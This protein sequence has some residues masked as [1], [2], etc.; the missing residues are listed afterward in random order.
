MHQQHGTGVFQQVVDR[1]P[2]LA[3]AF[4]GKMGHARF[5]QP[6]SQGQQVPGHR[7]KRLECRAP[8]AL[9]PYRVGHHPTGRHALLMDIPSR[10][11]W[12]HHVHATPPSTLGL[13]GYPEQERRP[14]VLA[15]PKAAGNS[16]WCRQGLQVQ[17]CR[18]LGAPIRTRPR[19][20]PF[21]AH[22]TGWPRHG[23]RPLLFHASWCPRGMR[24]LSQFFIWVNFGYDLPR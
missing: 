24:V 13:A 21:R 7:A 16:S 14:C 6:G 23:E 11:P 15:F 12:K 19:N 8:L 3:R 20:Q 5:R 4:H 22:G 17:C 2:V 1:F 9:W 10:A 18:R